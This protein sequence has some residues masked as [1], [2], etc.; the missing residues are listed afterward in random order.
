MKGRLSRKVMSMVHHIVCYIQI[1]KESDR[2]PSRWSVYKPYW[3]LRIQSSGVWKRTIQEPRQF[4]TIWQ[5]KTLNSIRG[6][7]ANYKIVF[8]V[9]PSFCMKLQLCCIH[10]CLFTVDPTDEGEGIGTLFHFLCYLPFLI[11]TH[12]C[13]VPAKCSPLYYEL[14]L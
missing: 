14:G 9:W 10:V 8:M 2:K 11:S 13:W 3:S 12:T 4:E 6:Q 1:Y 7:K 5:F